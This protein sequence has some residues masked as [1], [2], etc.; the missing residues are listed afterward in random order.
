MLILILINITK[1][2]TIPA[3]FPKRDNLWILKLRAKALEDVITL[4]PQS[5]DT[6]EYNLKLLELPCL[7]F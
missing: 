7:T 1:I 3:L 2:L 6:I 5:W 4:L